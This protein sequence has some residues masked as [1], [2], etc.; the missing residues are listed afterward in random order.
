MSWRVILVGILTFVVYTLS[1]RSG[2]S[3]K[4]LHQGLYIRKQGGLFYQSADWVALITLS[5]PP[6]TRRIQEFGA[7]LKNE[8]K[9]V[10]SRFPQLSAN[11]N[12]RIDTCIENLDSISYHRQKRAPLG[13][14]GKLSHTLFGTVTEE[15]LNQ[16]R[17]ILLDTRNSVNQ[18][19]HR[20]NL[21]LSATKSNRKNINLNS[22]HINR[23]QR[24]LLSIQR[25][26][27]TNFQ[28]LSY[29]IQLLSLK[30]KF[31]HSVTSLEQ[32]SHRILSIYH[33]RRRQ[34]N[35]LYR[36]TLSDELLPLSQLREILHRARGLRYATLPDQWYYENC[37]VIPIWTTPE[38]ITYKV[39]LPLHDGKHYFLYS[40][41]SFPYPVKPGYSGR[42]KVRQ[43]VAY[44]SSSGLLFEP[45]LCLGTTLK[46]C[47]GGPLYDAAQF[48][49][50]RALISR[51][52][53][54]TKDCKIKIYPTNTT[55]ITEYIPGLY[56]ISTPKIFPKLHCDALGEEVVKLM[57]GVYMMSLNHSCTLR[58]L[59]W[60]LP[61]LNK[62]ITPF[63]L[64]TQ[65]AP[66]S[67][68]TVLSPFSPRHLQ[69]LSDA[70]HWTPI[71]R[72][73]DIKLD[74]LPAPA[75]FMS[76]PLVGITTWANSSA[77]IVLVIVAAGSCLVVCWHRRKKF[78]RFFHKTCPSAPEELELQVRPTPLPEDRTSTVRLP[79]Y[80]NLGQ[81]PPLSG[82]V[83]SS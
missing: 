83:P 43:L 22:D 28:V 31:E 65:T 11:W 79:R 17:S 32:S 36:H 48:Q 41:H 80:P 9:K 2:I 74:P 25:T 82:T 4:P 51:D 75:P 10:R 58:G 38:D 63:H 76:L 78:P 34:V 26:I 1:A 73:P 45:I 37:R 16:Y 33:Q 14:I 60:T 47:R 72:L 53:A 64:K 77:I 30:L 56:I 61:G 42:V 62:Y 54:A 13:F 68:R 55:T 66:L 21:L 15:E 40:L 46:V 7:L 39:H 44:S 59:D 70:P 5:S 27:G 57:A 69:K 81:N 49:C 18:T 8:I 6:P 67:L 19:V 20:T 3:I 23:L 12:S 50:E 52:A 29:S 24:Y 35:H 71:S